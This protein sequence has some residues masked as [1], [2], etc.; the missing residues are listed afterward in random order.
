MGLYK[1]Q[2]L[3]LM[4]LLT[5]ALSKRLRT[6]YGKWINQCSGVEGQDSAQTVGCDILFSVTGSDD[7]H[8]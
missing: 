8:N 5:E 1:Y 7:T 3:D 4:R 6:V 2:S